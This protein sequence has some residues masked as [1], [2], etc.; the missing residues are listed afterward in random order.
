YERVSI[1]FRLCFKAGAKVQPLLT[2]PSFFFNYFESFF[3]FILNFLI[4]KNLD[5]EVLKSNGKNF[6]L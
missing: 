3:E 1:L 5:V 4:I 2:S 6:P